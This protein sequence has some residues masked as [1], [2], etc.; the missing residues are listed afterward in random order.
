MPLSYIFGLVYTYSVNFINN[1]KKSLR[2]EHI[3]IDVQYVYSTLYKRKTH[4]LLNGQRKLYLV[5][6]YCKNLCACAKKNVMV[7]FTDFFLN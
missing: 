7:K 6:K 2:G 3:E 4:A 1:G 5:L